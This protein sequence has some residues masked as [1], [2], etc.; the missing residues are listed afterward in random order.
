MK[1]TSH[2]PINDA[3]K[4]NDPFKPHESLLQLHKKAKT[5]RSLRVYYVTYERSLYS[6]HKCIT[7]QNYGARQH[8]SNCNIYA[9][10]KTLNA[11][12]KKFTIKKVTNKLKQWASSQARIKQFQLVKYVYAIRVK[13]L[14]LILIAHFIHSIGW[15]CLVRLFNAR[16]TQKEFYGFFL[17]PL[18]WPILSYYDGLSERSLYDKPTQEKNYRI[19]WAMLLKILLQ[20]F[21]HVKWICCI[22]EA[23][24]WWHLPRTYVPFSEIRNLATITAQQFN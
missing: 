20:T 2:R 15:N 24:N 6:A 22:A 11:K 7:I 9:K 17:L 19:T 1:S 23:K 21:T 10:I 8:T 14:Y 12:V 18:W 3:N 4:L 13:T 5:P 16:P